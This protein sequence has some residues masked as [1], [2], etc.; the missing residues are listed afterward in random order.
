VKRAL[1]VGI[2]E[3]ENFPSLGGCVNDVAALTPLLARHEDASVNF[4]CQARTSASGQILR[5]QLLSAIDGLLAPGADVALF[6]FAGH[7]AAPE[8]SD[9]TLVTSDGTRQSPGIKLSEL[10]TQVHSSQVGEVLVILDCCF[11]GGAGGLPQL[12]SAAAILRPG[13]SMLTASRADQPSAETAEGR[14]L[15]ST[16]LGGALDGGAA[17]VLGRVTVAGLYAYL[18]E[19]F[20]AWEQRPTLKA[21]IDRLHDLRQ[22]APAVPLDDLRRLPQLF[23]DPG[24]ELH[25]DPSYEPTAEPRGDPHEADF[26][27]LQHCRAAKLVEPVE[28]EHLYFAAMESTACRLTPLGRHYRQM[29]AQN[30]L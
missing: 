11:S 1:L 6:Y 9:V 4:D 24:A 27:V 15:F 5:D 2:D 22:C 25:L 12:G 28:A 8:N 3:Y 21:N 30:R 7:G 13:L 14:G 29:A 10:L 23:T 17:D 19:S 26:A 16:Y 18:T 20:G